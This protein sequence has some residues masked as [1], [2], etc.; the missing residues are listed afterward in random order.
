MHWGCICADAHL[1]LVVAVLVLLLA[2]ILVPPCKQGHEKTVED[3][4]WRPGSNAELA[5]VG[6]D[7]KLLLWDTR[8][9]NQAAAEVT[10]AHGRGKDLHC[11]DW[12]AL[13]PHLLVTGGLTFGLGP[14][15]SLDGVKLLRLKFTAPGCICLAL[16]CPCKGVIAW[17]LVINACAGS[18][19]QLLCVCC[20]NSL[21]KCIPCTAHVLGEVAS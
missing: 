15:C 12:S 13:Q 20:H 17:S 3:V 21:S 6:D 11:V 8:S 14:F 10:E 5:S 18:Q 2:N 19:L 4:V 16:V 1:V 9:P 7:F